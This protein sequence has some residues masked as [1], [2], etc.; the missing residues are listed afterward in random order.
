MLDKHFDKHMYFWNCL[1]ILEDTGRFLVGTPNAFSSFSASL[2]LSKKSFSDVLE[3]TKSKLK[4]SERIAFLK[5]AQRCEIKKIGKALVITSS[6]SFYQ[7]PAAS[8]LL[9]LG[10]D[11]ALVIGEEKGFTVLSA[12]AET[13][14]KEKYSFNLMTDLLSP[15]QKEFG[16]EC[17]GHS[18][19]AQ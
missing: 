7:S 9:S 18:G 13:S 11:I 4:E 16:G 2:R 1:G 8:A 6:L 12:R 5:A 14:F 3:F 15:L 10:A 17:G 19:A